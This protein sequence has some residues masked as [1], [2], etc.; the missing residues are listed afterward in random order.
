MKEKT[1]LALAGV[2]WHMWPLKKIHAQLGAPAELATLTGHEKN[3]C[4]ALIFSTASLKQLVPHFYETTDMI[5]SDCIIVLPP[6]NVNSH[7]ETVVT[8][9]F[10]INASDLNT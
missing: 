5:L 3:T 6:S 2:L 4:R 10:E 1:L 9:N 8:L 7:M